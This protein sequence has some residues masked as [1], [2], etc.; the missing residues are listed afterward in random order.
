MVER[1]NLFIIVTIIFVHEVF[2]K[3]ELGFNLP[4]IKIIINKLIDLFKSNNIL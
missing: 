3:A 4:L 2:D 1:D